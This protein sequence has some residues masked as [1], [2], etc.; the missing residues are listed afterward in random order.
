MRL[1]EFVFWAR[2]PDD[3]GSTARFHQV[4][5]D[6][7]RM[8]V[9]FEQFLRNFFHL[10]FTEYRV[11]SESQEWHVSEVTDG[12]LALLP[13]MITDITLRHPERTIVMDAKFYQ[14]PLAKGHYGERV[15]S[16]H[17]YQLVTYLQHER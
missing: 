7:V 6:E 12:D 2:M 10:H 17:L 14:T 5:E 8:S 11:R 9:V 13:R 1:C 16:Q 3:R 4:L 15:W